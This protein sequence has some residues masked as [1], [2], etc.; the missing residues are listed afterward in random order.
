MRGGAGGRRGGR[1]A[2]A[3]VLWEEAGAPPGR[4]TFCPLHSLTLVVVLPHASLCY[5]SVTRVSLP[6]VRSPCPCKQMAKA[7]RMGVLIDLAGL[8]PTIMA[9]TAPARPTHRAARSS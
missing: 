7:E 8:P 4:T 6:G 2:A 3:V 1:A 5:I 9:R